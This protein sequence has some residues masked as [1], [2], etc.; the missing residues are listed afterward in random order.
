MRSDGFASS[1]FSASVLVLEEIR[2]AFY[3]LYCLVPIVDS[4]DHVYGHRPGLRSSRLLCRATQR[5]IDKRENGGIL[6]QEGATL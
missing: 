6:E 4:D 3:Y 5:M 1:I 2:K